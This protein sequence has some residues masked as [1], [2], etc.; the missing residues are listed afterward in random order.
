[1]Q[2]DCIHDIETIIP[3]KASAQDI[4]MEVKSMLNQKANLNDVKKTMLEVAQNLDSKPSHMDIKRMLESKVDKQEL[5]H[6]LSQKLSFDDMKSYVDLQFRNH[7]QPMM[8]ELE[9]EVKRL[10][11]RVEETSRSSA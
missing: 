9:K 8:I 11:V 6:L 1:M 4:R 2:A 7:M 3:T 5:T 10:A